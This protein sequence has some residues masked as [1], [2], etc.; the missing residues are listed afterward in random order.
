MAEIKSKRLLCRNLPENREVAAKCNSKPIMGLCMFFGV[1]A[2]LCLTSYWIFGLIIA[3]L[4]L[5]GLF[6]IKNQVMTEFNEEYVVFYKEGDTEGCYLLYWEDIDRWKYQNGKAGLDY[7]QI[8]LK[9]GEMHTYKIFSRKK[10]LKYF[11]QYS[12]N[13]ETFLNEDDED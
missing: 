6:F 1:G 7:I 12:P 13:P 2:L 4:S 10:M 9:N 8:L 5:L 11:N 3:V